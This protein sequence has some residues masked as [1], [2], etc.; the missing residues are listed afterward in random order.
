MVRVDLTK[1]ELD[2]LID[3]IEWWY[4]PDFKFHT[5]EEYEELRRK[6]IEAKR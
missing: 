1:R 4:D 3:A 2:I 6:L 5:K